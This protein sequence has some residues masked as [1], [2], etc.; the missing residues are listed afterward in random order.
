MKEGKKQNVDDGNEMRTWKDRKRKRKLKE[1]PP[2][3]DQIIEVWGWNEK[4]D[5]NNDDNDHPNDD[6]EMEGKDQKN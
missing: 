5:K 4:R 1:L 3:N 6:D 2:K